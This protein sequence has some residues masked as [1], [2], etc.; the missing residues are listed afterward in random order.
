MQEI[1]KEDYH[2]VSYYKLREFLTKGGIPSDLEKHL[3]ERVLKEYGYLP[4]S[5]IA[6]YEK[7]MHGHSE[8][9]MVNC[10]YGKHHYPTEEEQKE[11]SELNA[12][13]FRLD[14]SQIAE[15]RGDYFFFP[16]I[17]QE[18]Q[19]MEQKQIFT[20]PAQ[21]QGFLCGCFSFSEQIRNYIGYCGSSGGLKIPFEAFK[22][23][24]LKTFKEN[25]YELQK[26]FCELE[27]YCVDGNLVFTIVPNTSTSNSLE[28]ETIK[29]FCKLL[30]EQ[31][32]QDGAILT[33]LINI[34]LKRPQ[35]FK[36]SYINERLTRLSLERDCGFLKTT[37][38]LMLDEVSRKSLKEANIP[39]VEYVDSAQDTHHYYFPV[40][41]RLWALAR[42]KEI[43]KGRGFKN[44]REALLRRLTPEQLTAL[45][46]LGEKSTPEKIWG[47]V[48]ALLSH[49]Q[50]PLRVLGDKETWQV[51]QVS[52]SF[53]LAISLN[54]EPIPEHEINKLLMLEDEIE[55]NQDSEAIQKEQPSSM[56]G[57]KIPEEPMAE[58]EIEEEEEEEIE[59]EW[60]M[61][62]EEDEPFLILMK[63]GLTNTTS[64]IFTR[65]QHYMH[66]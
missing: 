23:D 63:M 43:V 47:C 40:A 50:L 10:G 39:F 53:P 62:E 19:S 33:R 20:E 17:C 24:L 59:E 31:E 29:H 18:R 1:E 7:K 2:E 46:G 44:M 65:P 35:G 51:N 56:S 64:P 36:V 22:Q 5:C 66:I 41:F 14:F 21:I 30:E 26:A 52:N 27:L 37:H 16:K 38:L 28:R 13:Y 4:K 54:K 55:I 15:D 25:T 57:L 8:S 60:P 11:L 9:L 32:K 6:A 58:E 42:L 12:K 49:L 45:R 48:R 34:L 3:S 61:T